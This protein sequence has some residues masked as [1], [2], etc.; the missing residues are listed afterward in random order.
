MGESEMSEKEKRIRAITRMYYSNP[1]VQKVIADFSLGREVVPRYFE[2]FG[3]RPDIIQYPSDLTGMVAKGATS[4]HGSE[5]IWRDPL[6]LRSD[7]LRDEMNDLR[8]S[9]DLLIDIDSQF[10]DWSK[11]VAK[12]ILDVLESYGVNKYGVKYSGSR[13][14]HIIVSGDA[15]PA[16]FNGQEKRHAFPEWPRIICQYIGFVMRKQYQE[17]IKKFAPDVNLLQ[18]RMNKTKEEILETSCPACNGPS[19][20]KISVSFECP[21]CKATIKRRDFKKTARKLRCVNCPGILEIVN[22][23]EY[24]FCDECKTSS[25]D[26][27]T[28]SGSGTVTYTK[29]SRD[30]DG[31]FS[32]NFS[33]EIKGQAAGG[34]DLVLV[35]P[36]HLFRMPYSLHEKT[37]LSSI[38]ISKQELENFSP[39]DASPL[40]VSVREYKPKNTPGEGTKLLADALE[41]HQKFIAE[42]KR[43]EKKSYSSERTFTPVNLDNLTEAMYPAS[44][45]KLMLGLQDGKKRGLF[46]LITFLKSLG[47]SEEDI[48]EKVSKWNEKNEP[49]LKE[50]YVKSQ[51]VWHFRQKKKILP[52]N[53]DNVSFYQDLG[54]IKEKPK[55]KNPLV[56]VM[57]KLNRRN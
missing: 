4:F 45:K 26:K 35:S 55:V 23:E 51:L 2:G 24:F 9:W 10:L 21:D 39:R 36:R 49:P 42:E 32:S 44:I 40:K 12:L 46:V 1:K 41:W 15:F 20:K 7:I 52:P 13:G 19:V 54:L 34:Y 50:G 37:A 29:A 31:T 14:F 57:Q 16:E 22:E 43:N 18:K 11:I 6:A 33:E 5:E 56:E 8:T 25:F 53:Y 30:D 48:A 27:N 38:V 3:K 47:Y 17:Q 28:G